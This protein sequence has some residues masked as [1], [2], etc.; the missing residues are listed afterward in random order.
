LRK[1]ENRVEKRSPACWRLG[2]SIS[3]SHAILRPRYNNHRYRQIWSSSRRP[4][5]AAAA[6]NLVRRVFSP[7]LGAISEASSVARG[8]NWQTR[9][10]P[11]GWK[12]QPR[13]HPLSPHPRCRSTLPLASLERPTALYRAGAAAAADG[14]KGPA[15][16]RLIRHR[17]SLLLLAPRSNDNHVFLKPTFNMAHTRCLPKFSQG[18]RLH[19]PPTFFARFCCLQLVVVKSFYIEEEENISTLLAYPRH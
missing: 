3:N 18:M 12:F 15:S 19:R 1:S 4:I 2:K 11:K 13:P 17:A 14:Y 16:A 9:E 10:V 8:I 5:R 7:I 6:K